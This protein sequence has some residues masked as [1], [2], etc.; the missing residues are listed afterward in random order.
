MDTA[1]N[2]YGNTWQGGPGGGGTVWELSPSGSNYTFT[3]LYSVPEAALRLAAWPGTRTATSMKRC[4]TEEP[5]T[6]VR[7]SN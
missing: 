7:F 4:K 6:M 5:I 3:L 2:L 1:G